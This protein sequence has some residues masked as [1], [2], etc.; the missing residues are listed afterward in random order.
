MNTDDTILATLIAA[1]KPLA[2]LA[3]S[4]GMT[5]IALVQWMDRNADLLGMAKRAMETHVGFLTL[6]AEAAAIADLSAVSA[7]T[8]NEE[9]KRKSSSQLLRHVAKRLLTPS[10]RTRVKMG[11]ADDGPSR[12]EPALKQVRQSPRASASP[13]PEA[14]LA[15][16]PT[17]SSALTSRS[18]LLAPPRASNTGVPTGRI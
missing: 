15:P 14:N 1:D 18:N 9:R 8:P 16:A 11:E 2:S 10:R 7:S 6:H 12:I 4:L 13:P 17:L 5:L 3:T